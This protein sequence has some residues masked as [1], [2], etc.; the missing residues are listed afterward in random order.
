MKKNNI[1]LRAIAAIGFK[2]AV[3]ASS[4]AS[5]YSCYQPKEPAVLKKLKK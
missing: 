4:A 2:S 3:K 5:A 1:V